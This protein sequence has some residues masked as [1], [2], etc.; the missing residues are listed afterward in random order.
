TANGPDVSLEPRTAQTLALALH[1]LS[2]NAAKYGALSVMSGRVDLTWELQ[3]EMLVLRW[4]ESGGPST[5]PPATPGFGIRVISASIERQLDGEAR[6]E[7]QPEGLRCSLAV[8]RG[9]KIDA[10]GR[11]PR[12]HRIAF[13]E[14]PSIPLKLEAGNRV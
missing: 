1:E 11:H 10:M 12:P 8:P 7:W 4:S 2:T 3:P 6:F 13:E 5:Q 14:Q 9:D